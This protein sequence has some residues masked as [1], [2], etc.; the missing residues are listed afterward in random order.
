MARPKLEF[1]KHFLWGVSTSAHQIEGSQHNQWSVWELENARTL[2]TKSSFQYEDLESW[3]RIKKQAKNPDNYV[4]GKAANHYELFSHDF[5]LAR[6]LNLNAWRFSIEW[7]R[8]QPNGPEDWNPDAVRHYKRYVS[9][10]KRRGL[11]P[12][13][14]LFHFTLP[15]W[16]AEM[17]GFE[18][19]SNV[20]HFVSFADRILDELGPSVKFVITVNEPEVYA[21][22]S[23]YR[24]H[25]PPQVQSLKRTRSVLNNLAYAHNKVSDM[26]HAKSRRFKVSIAKNSAFVFP[27]DDAWL[28]VRSAAIMQY[29]QDDYF[30]KKVVKKCDF[31][32]VNYYFSSRIYGY[33]EHNPEDHIS[34]LGWDMHPADIELV[35]ERLYEKYKL[36]IMITEN[37]LADATDEQRK[38]WL[39]QT[40][41]AL[42]KVISHKIPVIGYLHWSIID[43]FEWDKGFWPRFGLYEVNYD[44]FKRT[45]RRSAVWLA[46][47]LKKIR[48][49]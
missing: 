37:G 11:E 43:N 44:D 18:K 38:W 19:R 4:S 48:E 26:A 39:T 25:W 14:T 30:L 29:V 28:S 47:V 5:D 3:E 49:V 21:I 40:L 2:A 45:P 36:P 8:L 23:Y 7:S 46:H 6:K 42:S 17:G 34:D 20:K 15:V 33:R 41:L 16:F 9:E 24:G 35:I 31:M 12:V 13:V 22:E 32:G 1:P 10:M 27:G